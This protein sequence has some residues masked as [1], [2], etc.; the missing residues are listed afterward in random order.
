MVTSTFA[1]SP[2]LWEQDYYGSLWYLRPMVILNK[3]VL[4]I[5][6]IAIALAFGIFTVKIVAKTNSH[7]KPLTFGIQAK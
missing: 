1:I 3:C 4:S 2:L 6:F 5:P 7:Y